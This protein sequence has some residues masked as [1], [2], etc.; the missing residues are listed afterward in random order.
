MLRGLLA[1]FACRLGPREDGHRPVDHAYHS[2]WEICQLS[3]DPMIGQKINDRTN[4][5]EYGQTKKDPDTAGRPVAFA[6]NF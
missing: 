5:H 6:E 2:R 3:R 1:E 4:C